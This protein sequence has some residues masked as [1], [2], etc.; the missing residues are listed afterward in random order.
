MCACMYLCG[1]LCVYMCMSV[2][3]PAGAG[4]YGSRVATMDQLRFSALFSN[5]LSLKAAE[6]L[7]YSSAFNLHANQWGEW[8]SPAPF[9]SF[10][11]SSFCSFL[12]P[13][14]LPPSLLFLLLSNCPPFL[15]S[16]LSAPG[17]WSGLRRH[18]HEQ[19]TKEDPSLDFVFSALFLLP[20]LGE[21][22]K[23]QVPPVSVKPVPAEV[24]GPSPCTSKS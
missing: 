7:Q 19:G 12:H 5:Q 6:I 14:P 18:L 10:S 22:R 20:L 17:P 2:W 13:P 9:S 24:R 1:C 3:S 4:T 16:F 21:P 15:I 8:P 23:S 11:L